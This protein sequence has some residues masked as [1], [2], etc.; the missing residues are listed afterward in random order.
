[1]CEAH[2][3]RV[4]EAENVSLKAQLALRA[5]G[6]E[7][8]LR[9]ARGCTDYG[10][11]HYGREHEIYQ[12]GV[13]TVITALERA[14]VDDLQTQTLLA[15]GENVERTK[16]AVEAA[17]AAGFTGAFYVLP[18]APVMPVD[19]AL[20]VKR[21]AEHPLIVFDNPHI[22][23]PER[24]ASLRRAMLCGVAEDDEGPPLSELEQLQLTHP[25]CS[26][27]G[28][29]AVCFGNCEG[30]ANHAYGCSTCCG[31]GNEDGWCVFLTD[32]AQIAATTAQELATQNNKLEDEN[33]DLKKEPP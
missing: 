8:A 18:A 29:L 27:C 17:H 4:V 28:S 26:H 23:S 7:T 31:H 32:D 1:V 14:R 6:Y 24:L 19:D 25:K 21:E 5:G 33:I 20:R 2:P 13:S 12:H 15:I 11:G 30:P 10:G 16:E 9:I 22:D 3:M